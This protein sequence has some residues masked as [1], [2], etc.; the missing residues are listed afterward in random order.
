MRKLSLAAVLL[1]LGI[2]LACVSCAGVPKRGNGSMVTLERTVPT[3]ERLRLNGSARVNYHSSQ[4]YRVIVTVDSNLE[5]YL[6]IYTQNKVLNIG[7]KKGSY[8]FTEYIVDVYC[9]SLS[10]VSISGSGRFTGQDKIE[11]ESFTANI[12]GSGDINC[13]ITTN[14]L[15]VGISGSGDIE[16]A[17]SSKDLNMTISG[18]GN[19]MGNELSANTADIRISGSGKVQVWVLE[20]LKAS[21]SGAGSIRYRGNPKIEFKGSGSGR[22]TSA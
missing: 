21:F 5:E 18:S 16:V 8:S 13:H 2:S 12:S 4:E 20:Y 3:F 1:A 9:P 7:T 19:F 6:D 22:I 10:G 14:S 17:G 11:C 15:N